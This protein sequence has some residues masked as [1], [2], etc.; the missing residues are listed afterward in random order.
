[1][2]LSKI[3]TKQQEIIRLLYR[4]RFLDRTHIQALLHHRDKRRII[5]WLKDLRDKQYIGWIYNGADFAEKTKPAIYFIALNGIRHL[6]A[7]EKLPA[8][9]LRKRYRDAQRAASFVT[10]SLLI[11][12]YCITLNNNNTKNTEFSY[13][14]VADYAGNN[15]HGLYDLKP[16]LHFTKQ[17]DET[18]TEY[19]LEYFDTSLPRYQLKNRIKGYIDHL[20]QEDTR[21]IALF[22]FATIAD[23]IYAKRLIR[24]LTE[25]LDGIT[26]RVA[27][28]EKV[29]QGGILAKIWEQP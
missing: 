16:H 1:M 12:G 25:D 8:T 20:D 27:P 5:S 14:L 23:L 6:R 28:L 18:I 4:Y 13:E 29:K 7:T 17:A 24:R 22:V 3:T 15:D 10:R 26:I 9:E 21:S 19:L 2:P 11:A